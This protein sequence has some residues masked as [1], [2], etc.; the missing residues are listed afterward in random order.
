MLLVY[1]ILFFFVGLFISKVAGLV[2]DQVFAIAQNIN[3]AVIGDNLS[4]QGIPF[5]QQLEPYVRQFINAVDV[6]SAATQVQNVFNFLSNQIVSISIGL[7]NTLIVLVLTFFMVVEERF[8][9]DFF[10]TIFPSKYG[11]YVS[12]R[13]AAVKDNIGLWLRGQFLVSV[14]AA[15][16]SYIGLALMGVNYALTLALISGVGMTI[17]VVGR[18]FAWVPTVLIVASQSPELAFWMSIYYLIVQQFENNLI[19]PYVMNKA[20]GLNPIVIIFAL[21]VG[22]QFLPVLGWVLAIPV[23]TTIASFVKDFTQKGKGA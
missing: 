5:G 9:D 7:F 18:F 17:P 16:L 19:V 8:I 13:M 2:A 11:S 6:Q 23:A 12:T 4:L 15:I 22:G 10:L 14:I 1:V 3:G 20:V 21:M